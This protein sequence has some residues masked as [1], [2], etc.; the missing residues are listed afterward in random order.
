MIVKLD[1]KPE[2]AKLLRIELE[3]EG[4]VVLRAR[5]RGDFFAH[6]EESFEAAEAELGGVSLGR[7][8]ETALAAFARPGLT[9]YGASPAL[10]AEALGR[11]AHAFAVR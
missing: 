4:G 2:G 6:P 9:M 5:V 10:I 7:L 1:Y 3:A 11:A 8:A